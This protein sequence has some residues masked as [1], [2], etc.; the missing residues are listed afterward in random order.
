[1][2]AIAPVAWHGAEYMRMLDA[3]DDTGILALMTEDTQVVDEI[4]RRWY[5]GKH[6]PTVFRQ[7]VGGRLFVR[8][9]EPVGL[10][11]AETGLF[12]ALSLTCSRHVPF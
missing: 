7:P 9:S 2:A 1:M 8:P 3:R 12:A 4:T 5:R 10:D 11:R 6:E